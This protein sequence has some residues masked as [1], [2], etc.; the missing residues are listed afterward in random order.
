MRKR[1]FLMAY[2]IIV[3]LSGCNS[4][5]ETET[6]EPLVI[7]KTVDAVEVG[8]AI[9]D[10]FYDGDM[11]YTVNDS[12]IYQNPED[13]GIAVE[14]LHMPYN[15][16]ASQDIKEG[17]REV[18]D[19]ILEDGS[20]VESHQLLVLDITIKNESALGLEKKIE[21][22]IND[23]SIWGGEPVTQYNIVY[24]GE[25]GKLEDS[26]DPFYYEI[27]QGQ[28]IKTQI[29]FLILKEDLNKKD[30]VGKIFEMQFKIF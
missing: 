6:V 29:G 9:K 16:Y 26:D 23:I 14:N 7:D 5:E 27:K 15:L 20:I 22:S 8:D 21:F 3:L 30:L 10:T 24:F 17:Y 13:A 2:V 18:S 4:L 1:F 11:Y 25:T 19:Y 12:N 28:E